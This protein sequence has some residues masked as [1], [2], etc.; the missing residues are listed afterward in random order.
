MPRLLL[1]FGAFVLATSSAR[2]DEVHLAEG[3]VLVG[4][5]TIEG[6]KVVV[7]LE[8]GR[9]TVPRS[10]VTR[11]EK[12]TTPLAQADARDAAL[13]PSDV[14]GMLALAN[15]CRDHDL[16]NKE[17]D[18]LTRILTVAPNHAEA[19]RRL[20]F[21]R[22]SVDGHDTWVDHAEIAKHEEAERLEHRQAQASLARKEAE[23]AA[24]TVKLQQDRARAQQ[25][26]EERAQKANSIYA[27]RPYSSYGAAPYGGGY[28][29][30]GG[31]YGYGYGY[32]AASGRHLSPPS[33][34]AP[35][36]INGVRS[37]SDMGFNIPGVR[38]PSSYFPASP[39]HH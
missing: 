12:S 25:E 7:E 19:R 10:E 5:A 1:I 22:Q 33:G 37:P 32:G 23:L 21:V 24:A 20:G 9:I 13:K 3:Q 36:G 4:T 14:A 6:D 27:I 15:Y 39:H 34:G 35:F 18:L 11:I 30:Y 38:A 26:E 8:S 29:P 16:F 2:A 28:G 31:G 17:R